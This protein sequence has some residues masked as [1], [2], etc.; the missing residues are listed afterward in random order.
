MKDVN[1]RMN[2]A[3]VWNRSDEIR[4]LVQ[5]VQQDGGQTGT[6]RRCAGKTERARCLAGNGA[7]SGP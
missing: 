3:I 6:K 4:E 5:E 1:P 2:E 7:A